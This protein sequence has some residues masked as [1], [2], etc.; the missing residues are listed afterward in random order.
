[1]SNLVFH[2]GAYG[3]YQIMYFQR[4]LDSSYR[5]ILMRLRY[6]KK[7]HHGITDKLLYESLVS[8]YN[9]SDL[10][11]DTACNP[12]YF[13]RIKLLRHGGVSGH[14]RK[15]N[16]WVVIAFPLFMLTFCYHNKDGANPRHRYGE[17]HCVF[18]LK[19]VSKTS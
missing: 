15:K 2:F 5:I 19:L 4:S 14:V 12:F 8:R 7:G 1:M 11:E 16:C 18:D 3:F 17:E 6:S 9:F 10:I 13:F